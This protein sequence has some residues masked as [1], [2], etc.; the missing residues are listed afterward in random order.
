MTT[1]G[2]PNP[3]RDHRHDESAPERGT[4]ESRTLPTELAA[5]VAAAASWALG[6]YT[7]TVRSP[8]GRGRAVLVAVAIVVDGVAILAGNLIGGLALS[9]V[10]I[11]VPVW[12]ACFAIHGLYDRRRFLSAFDEAGRLFHGVTVATVATLVMD[13]LLKVSVTREAVAVVWVS[14]LLLTGACRVVIRKTVHFLHTKGHLRTQVL[15][16]GFNDE[17]QSIGRALL[18]RGWTG[19]YPVGFVQTEQGTETL[20]ADSIPVVGSLPDLP[21]IVRA[22]EVDAVVLASTALDPG[23]LPDLCEHLH[24]LGVE[25]RISAG[26]PQVAASRVNIEPL[27]GVAVLS[28]KPN[29]LSRNQSAIK[30]LVDVIGSLLLF[31]LLAPVLASIALTVRLTSGGPIIFRQIRVGQGGTP[32]VIYKFRT[33][34]R[35]AESML[36]EILDLNEAT[37]PLFK[38]SND[39]RVTKL[40]HLLRRLGLDELPQLYNV[41]RGDMSLVGPRPP[42]PGETDRY[43]EWVRGRLRVKPGITGLWQV[44][45]GHHL[46]FDDYV[47]YDLFYIANWSLVLDLYIFARTL[48]TVLG[49]HR[50][51]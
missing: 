12:V 33:M 34:V 44:N 6:S 26:L 35:Q 48:P 13:F 50:I 1:L 43:D 23:Q 2:I 18:R 4:D 20:T 37:G 14:C 38:V 32:F 36:G 11:A 42:L 47:R 9:T 16:V 5:P 24:V 15:I 25:M 28:I 30:R 40:G 17:A 19:Y 22:L 8:R 27:D 21:R 39:P 10:L 41:L 49:R 7:R 3:T 31:V 29:E 46:G 51:A 45:G